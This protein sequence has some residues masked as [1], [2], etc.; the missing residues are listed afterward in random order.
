LD[1]LVV[2]RGLAPSRSKAQQL[3]AAGDVEVLLGGSW[4][5]VGQSSFQTNAEVRLKPESEILKYVS[6]GGLKL[7][8]ALKHLELDVRG[9]RALDLGVSTGGFSDCLLKNGAAEVL[10]V[11][12]GHGQLDPR[13]KIR[14]FEGVN[15]KEIPSH[16]EI[17]AWIKNGV[18]LCVAD[19]S[20]ISFLSLSHVLREFL[21]QGTRLLAL[22][23]PQFELGAQALNKSGVVADPTLYAGL[24]SRA[25]E[26]F[27]GDF[28]PSSIKGQDGNQEFFLY[29]QI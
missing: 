15:V 16:R 2:E 1:Q 12:V 8:G 3:I 18:D 22:I 9:F 11:D 28:F 25:L 29:S 20:F 24:R 7:E 13:L 19:L 5:S 23:K 4:Q 6:R 14:H 26:V 10:G 27:P 17:G 21:P